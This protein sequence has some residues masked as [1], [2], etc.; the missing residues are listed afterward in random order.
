MGNL[1]FHSTVE[2]IKS[3]CPRFN[4][5]VHFTIHIDNAD[6]PPDYISTSVDIIGG[7]EA[8]REKTARNFSTNQFDFDL[9]TTYSISRAND[10]HLAIGLCSQVLMHLEHGVSLVSVSEDGLQP[11][12]LYTFCKFC[13]RELCFLFM[14]LVSI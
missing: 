2:I 9:K 6:P 5:G 14:K 4:Y 11:P 1:Q 13:R 3:L 10:G 7:L 8:T 12:E